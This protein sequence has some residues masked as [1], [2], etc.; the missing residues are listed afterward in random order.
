M[1]AIKNTLRYPVFCSN[2]K[3]KDPIY[4]GD[5][6]DLFN[7]KYRIYLKIINIKYINVGDDIKRYDILKKR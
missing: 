1:A 4:R 6:L 5:S 2:I 7:L 3:N